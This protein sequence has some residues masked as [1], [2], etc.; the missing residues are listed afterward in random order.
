MTAAGLERYGLKCQHCGELFSLR[1]GTRAVGPRDL[2]SLRDPSQAKCPMCQDVA[3]YP[4]SSI[5]T[6]GAVSPI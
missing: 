1:V 4:K 6:L 2:E 3:A 5:E